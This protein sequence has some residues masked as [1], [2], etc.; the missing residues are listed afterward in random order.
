MSY[1]KR[2]VSDGRSSD[3][4]TK[5][6]SAK[7][8]KNQEQE[9]PEEKE[10]KEISM[11]I[12]LVIKTDYGISMNRE[13]EIIE[14]EDTKALIDDICS[15]LVLVHKSIDESYSLIEASHFT[16]CEIKNMLLGRPST[17]DARVHYPSFA[18]KIKAWH[19]RLPKLFGKEI[20]MMWEWPMKESKTPDKENEGVHDEG[21]ELD[22]DTDQDLD[23]GGDSS[24]GVGVDVPSA[25]AS[26]PVA[27]DPSSK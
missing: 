12:P 20:R 11:L 16:R 24:V 8:P 21:E 13:G 22:E 3:N 9:E 1:P 27:V 19:P 17:A 26:E 7:R 4:D 2:K 14:D 10:E 25:M 5:V 15:N 6:Y 23:E 18:P